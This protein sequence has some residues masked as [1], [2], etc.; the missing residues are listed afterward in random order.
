MNKLLEDRT[1]I[2]TGANRGIGKSIVENFAI[3]G[4]NI[5]A[6]VKNKTDEIQNWAIQTKKNFI[7]CHNLKENRGSTFTYTILNKINNINKFM[8]DL[9]NISY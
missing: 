6:C 8:I 9:D 7:G 2:I 4:S 3:N 5:I 1:A